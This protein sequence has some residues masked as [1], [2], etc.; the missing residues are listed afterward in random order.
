MIKLYMLDGEDEMQSF[1]LEGNTIYIGRSPDNDIK[2][3]DGHVSRRHLKI[4]RWGE[5][6]FVQDLSSKNGTYVNGRLISPG[7]EI[8]V[9]EGIPITIGM[10]LICLGRACLEEVVP[11]VES[12]YDSNEILQVGDISLKDRPM[13]AQK[14]MELIYHVSEALRGS[15]TLRE[16]LDRLLT[17]IFELLRRIDRGVIILIDG[18]SGE[19]TEVFSRFKRAGGAAA[20]AYS[21][22]VVK[23][24]MEDK[25]AIMMLDTCREQ[26]P[27]D[28]MQLMRIRSV[29]CLPLI[30]KSKMRGLIYLDSIGEPNGF[31]NEDLSLLTALSAPAALAIENENLHAGGRRGG[32]LNWTSSGLQ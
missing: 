11:F 1:D 26:R 4:E 7:V 31:R 17:H 23:R 9:P 29:M 15:M 5:R 20:A 30:S 6:F 28:S 13:T 3:N 12:I 21:R 10:S 25:R 18:D 22:T 19:I 2:M 16:I 8:E 14:N 24:V 32:L 27:S